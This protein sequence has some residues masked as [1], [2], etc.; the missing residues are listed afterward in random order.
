MKREK[1]SNFTVGK[2]DKYYLNQVIKI[3]N[4]G[5][6]LVGQWL[7]ICLPM[8]GTWVQSLV[9]EDPTRWGATKPVCHN[10]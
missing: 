10:Y 2:T 3:N 9:Q 6:S 1:K 5:T 8:L 4:S 7:R